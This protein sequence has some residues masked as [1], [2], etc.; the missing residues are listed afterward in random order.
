MKHN[1]NI[2]WI[3]AALGLFILA[4]ATAQEE[5][6]EVKKDK[7][8]VIIKKTHDSSEVEI[9]DTIEV[10]WNDVDSIT[11]PD[12]NRKPAGII[13]SG[14][15]NIGFA[16][17]HRPGM[18]YFGPQPYTELPELK[19]GNSI[20]VGIENNWGFNLIRGKLRLWLGLRYDIQNYRFNDADMRIAAGQPYFTSSLDSMSNST[21]S[22][23]VVNYIG[24]PI[25]I[26]F[27]S[28]AHA[29]EDGF[30]VRAGV[31]GGYRVRSHTKVKLET[32]NKDK[33]FDDFNFNDFALTPFVYMGYN[34][35]GLYVRYTTTPLF[36]AGQGEDAY[37]FQFGLIIQ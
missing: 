19:N 37:A 2:K 27:Q 16:N 18:G 12:V 7:R 25:A 33:V 28:N 5:K 22:K 11:P 4:P 20:H 23:M 32:G 30:F 13:S 1:I 14:N 3:A 8:I 34:S 31:N 9:R 15:V 6:P 24:V 21:K 17:I 29:V 36:K 10:H 35:V 26:G